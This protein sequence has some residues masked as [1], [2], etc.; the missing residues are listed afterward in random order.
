MKLVH[1]GSK[2]GEEHRRSVSVDVYI[3]FVPGLLPHGGETLPASA[4]KLNSELP[5][6]WKPPGPD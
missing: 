4:F 6:A 2:I 5:L 1:W 3:L